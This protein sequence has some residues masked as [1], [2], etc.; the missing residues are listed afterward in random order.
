MDSFIKLRI[1]VKAAILN[2]DKA[3]LI[4][5]VPALFVGILYLKKCR[6]DQP[7]T[8]NNDKL[9]KCAALHLQL[10]TYCVS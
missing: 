1:R 8:E 5:W 3:T 2:H 7:S 9:L 4:P 10:K 6:N